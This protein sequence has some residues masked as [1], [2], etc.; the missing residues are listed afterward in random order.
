MTSVR[1]TDY[2]SDGEDVYTFEVE[3]LAERVRVILPR[4]PEG[5]TRIWVG[6]TYWTRDLGASVIIAEA[7]RDI[8]QAIAAFQDALLRAYADL[9]VAEVLKAAADEALRNYTTETK[10]N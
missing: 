6:E 5:R 1:I 3:G 4:D 2:E 9:G 8:A 10:E 7:W